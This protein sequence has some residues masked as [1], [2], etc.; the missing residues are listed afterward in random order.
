MKRI[1]LTILVAAFAINMNAQIEVDSTGRVGIGTST[2]NA[3]LNI[4]GKNDASSCIYCYPNTCTTG[5]YIGNGNTTSSTTFGLQV[6][7]N[8]GIGNSFGV[9]SKVQGKNGE[10]NTCAIGVFGVAGRAT[11]GI[12]VFGGK[13]DSTSCTKFAGV[14]GSMYGG[15]NPFAYSGS[16]AG[17][18]NGD[19]RVASGKLYATVLSPTASS[20][21]GNSV[22]GNVIISEREGERVTEKLSR[23]Q[24]ILFTRDIR[25]R[26]YIP[27]EDEM[28]K[29]TISQIR[30][31]SE[32]DNMPKL[33]PIQYGLDPDQLKEAYPELVYE[34]VDGNVSINYVE[35]VPLL[36][37]SIN[38]LSQELAELKG[39]SAKKAKA[40]AKTEATSIDETASEVDMVRMDQNKPNP[41]SESTVITLN[42]PQET[43][44]ATIFIYDMSG[45]QVQAIPV[46]E[47]GETNITVYASDLTAGMYIYTLVVDG[48]V[49]VTRKMIVSEV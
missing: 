41:F 13:V 11:T 43:Q 33:S 20:G 36:V 4:R 46:N 8:N 16:Y 40:K 27:E 29:D 9:H 49:K 30:D 7:K 15:Q 10:S 25:D 12:G 48:K 47:R 19:V 17:Y 39:T 1:V 6:D 22:N 45:K 26:E 2:S 34:D 37:K 5:M 3:F 38:E 42:I 32:R 21:N 28:E 35:M 24:T 18:F 31:A 44:K 14:Y 23:I